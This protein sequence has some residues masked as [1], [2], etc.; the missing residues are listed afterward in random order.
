MGEYD[1][2]YVAAPGKPGYA[3][4]YAPAS[5]AVTAGVADAASQ[6]QQGG[7]TDEVVQVV[8]DTASGAAA[9]PG[10]V[11]DWISGEAAKTRQTVSDIADTAATTFQD[12]AGSGQNAA[13][14]VVKHAEEIAAVEGT[15]AL[16]VLTVAVFAGVAAYR[17]GLI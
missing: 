9:I 8:K 12:V 7:L 17:K 6:A 1:T 10:K 15:V 4:D 11:A 5:A 2:N 13:A 14:D 3:G 16:L